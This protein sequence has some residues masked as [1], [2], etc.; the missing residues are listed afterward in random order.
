[1]KIVPLYDIN[2]IRGVMMHEDILP[3]IIDDTWN[4]TV[5]TPDLNEIPIEV[6]PSSL[7]ESGETRIIPLDISQHLETNYPIV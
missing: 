1:M 6:F 5:Y 7:H 3:M 2:T 4:G